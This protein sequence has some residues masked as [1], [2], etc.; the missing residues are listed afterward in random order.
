MNRTSY[1]KPTN[2]LGYEILNRA[3]GKR[4]SNDRVKCNDL[5]FLKWFG[6]QHHKAIFKSRILKRN[7]CGL[8]KTSKKSTKDA[9]NP[10]QTGLKKTA[11]QP[12]LKMKTT[13]NTKSANN[14]SKS[15]KA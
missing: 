3:T 5:N 4:N 15:S 10:T 14:C 13:D 7:H 1:A 6:K 8:V 11:S 9:K 12:I 2:S